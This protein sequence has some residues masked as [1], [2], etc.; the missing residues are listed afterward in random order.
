MIEGIARLILH[1]RINRNMRLND[2]LLT[3]T[4][5]EE[6]LRLATKVAERTLKISE[7]AAGISR[8]YPPKNSQ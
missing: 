7:F 3:E 1:W 4:D 6:Q 5:P 2:K 8:R